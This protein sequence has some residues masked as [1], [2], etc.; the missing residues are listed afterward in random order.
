M[1]AN[2][3]C[4]AGGAPQTVIADIDKSIETRGVGQPIASDDLSGHYALRAREK[5]D[6]GLYDEAMQD[7]DNAIS[8]DYSDAKKVFNDGTV[9]PSDSSK[10]CKWTRL[11]LRVLSQMRPL[12]F[13]PAL[14]SALYEVF[15]FSW[16][17]DSDYAGVLETLQA[18]ARLSK[19]S[20]LPEYVIGSLL[21]APPGK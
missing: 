2:L 14:Y 16:K 11:D 15:F 21:G 3:Q 13:R 17:L 12:D 10:R 7:I 19:T 4:L 18:A 6:L 1:R 20:P 9:K 5:F 8:E